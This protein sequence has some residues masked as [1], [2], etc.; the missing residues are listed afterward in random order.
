MRTALVAL[1]LV[2]ALGVAACGDDASTPESAAAGSP[3]PA[4]TADTADT[5]ERGAVTLVGVARGLEL[6]A[7]P[8]IRVVD[9]RTPEEFSEGRIERAEL[10][11]FNA[12]G[13]RERIGELDRDDTYFIYCRSGN[14][15]GQATAIMAELGFTKV[16]DL[17]GGIT[18]WLDAGA[19]VVV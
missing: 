16:Y 17:D 6:V 7:D 12:A 1:A 15:S 4:A 3:S 19:P 9:V 18:A 8:T 11:D 2:G 5:A 14:R 13:F 10:I